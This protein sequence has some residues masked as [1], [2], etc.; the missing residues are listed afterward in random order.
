[1]K[2]KDIKFRKQKEFPY[3]N[4]FKNQFPVTDDNIFVFKDTIYHDNPEEIPYDVVLHEMRHMKQQKEIGA[5]T[6]VELYLSNADFR[7]KMEID[8]YRHQLREV[9][10][11][12]NNDREEINNIRNE[13]IQ[14]LTCGMYGKKLTFQEAITKLKI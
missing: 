4:T 3:L 14:N 5:I 12:T 13:I 11:L 9:K 6:W 1:M 10:K 8:A 2:I 7:L